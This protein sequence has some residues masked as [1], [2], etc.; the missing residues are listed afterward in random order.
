[1]CVRSRILKYLEYKQISKY[2][3]Y[4]EVGVANGFLDKEGSIGT[5]KCEKICYCYPDI[6]PEWLLLGKEPMLRPGDAAIYNNVEPPALESKLAPAE[7]S[8][9]YSMILERSERLAG[10]NGQLRAENERLKAENGNLKAENE[11]LK[12]KKQTYRDDFSDIPPTLK[13]DRQE[14]EEQI[15]K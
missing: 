4:K 13:E 11:K 6:N 2:R 15:I 5:D 8:V 12:F 10:E 9:L 7:P 3:F 14:V 1:M